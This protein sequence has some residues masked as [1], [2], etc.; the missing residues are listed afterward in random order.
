MCSLNIFDVKFVHTI[1]NYLKV[2]DY[3]ILYVILITMSYLI[4]M[5]FAKK[6]FKK[7]AMVTLGEEV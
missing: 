2:K 5:K 3:I 7:S 6:L 4:S 1:I